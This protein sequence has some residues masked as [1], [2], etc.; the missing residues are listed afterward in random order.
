LTRQPELRHG[1]SQRSRRSGKERRVSRATILVVEDDPQVRQVL[2]DQLGA[3]GHRILI[4]P[5]AE[6]AIGVLDRDFPD[7][8]LTDVH[9]GAM[10]GIELCAR[11]K[12]DPRYQ[13]TPVVILTA[14]S[15]L[16]GRIAGLEA[17]ADDFFPKPVHLVELRTRLGVLLKVK[18][19]VDQLER[20]EGVL[21]MLARTIEARDPYTHG[22]CERL[23]RYAVTLGRTLGLGDAA[24]KAL[25]LGGFLH[26]LGKIAVPD[27]I[28][29]KPGALTPEE[30][31]QM[32]GHA[33]AGETLV[34]DLKTLDS[35][36]PII[37]HHHERWDGTGYPD[38]LRGEAIP[39]E[40][41]IMAV[42]DVY[43]AL[44]TERP[45]KHAL[46]PEEAVPILL[47]ETEGG[48]WDPRV[49]SSFLELLEDGELGS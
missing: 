33:A 20:A 38:G 24:L 48:A 22:H 36:R 1:I 7:L 8:I 23:G 37:R 34:R 30:R 47:R 35:V 39:L 28:L 21:A 43:D 14:A 49:V 31:D 27:R 12:A 16:A 13:L 44:V 46:S 17:G 18:S 4:A 45:Y 3:L 5:S 40:G 42:V 11:L 2:G 15:D 41:R 19:L 26:D 9:M 32:Q 10:S 6:E 25:L 29:L